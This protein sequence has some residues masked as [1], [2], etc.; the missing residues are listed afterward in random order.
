L[1]NKAVEIAVREWLRTQ[2][3]ISAAAELSPCANAK[4]TVVSPCVKVTQ[5]HHADKQRYCGAMITASNLGTP[6]GVTV[7][8]LKA[9]QYCTSKQTTKNAYSTVTEHSD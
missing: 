3:P 1:H 7:T 5:M 6:S 2:E 9:V 8:T 4:V